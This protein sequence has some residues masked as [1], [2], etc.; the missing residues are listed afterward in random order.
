MSDYNN[1]TETE[2]LHRTCDE[3]RR[4]VDR[5]TEGEREGDGEVERGGVDMRERR[6]S[7]EAE[8]FLGWLEE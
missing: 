1:N 3:R 6:E 8:I 4:T 7:R 5:E 2:E